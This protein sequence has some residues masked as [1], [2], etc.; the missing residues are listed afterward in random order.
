MSSAAAARTC[1]DHRPRVTYDTNSHFGVL[2]QM[3]GS[4]WPRVLPHCLLNILNVSAIIYLDRKYDIDLSYSDKGHSFMSMIVSF[5]IVTRSNIAYSRFMESRSYLSTVMRSCRELMQYAVT[6]TRY[7]TSETA[8]KYRITL[9]RKTIVLL[10]SVVSVLQFPSR[11][12]HSWKNPILRDDE[13]QA[14]IDAV[15]EEDNVRAPMILAMFLRTS[16]ASHIEYLMTPMHVNREL[17]LYSFVSDF[18]SGY[19][20]LTK[21][22]DTQFPFPLAQMTRTFVFIWVYSLPWVLYNDEIKTPSLIMIVFFITYAFVGLECVSIELD[23]PYGNDANDFDV[24]GLAYVVF[25][26]IQICI[27]DVD[28]K[29][30]AEKLDQF[31]VFGDTDDM[32]E[33]SIISE[34]SQRSIQNGSI[35]LP[36]PA[37][38]RR[39][40]SDVGDKLSSIM[41]SGKYHVDSKSRKG[42]V[43]GTDDG[44]QLSG[45]KY[46]NER[47]PLLP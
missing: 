26:D 47:H 15:G 33:H 23:D 9:A 2:T 17:R 20:G 16:I 24:L 35:S 18:V 6:F 19:H 1:A 44:N 36:G 40:S 32:T 21:L 34:K 37:H 27:Y 8:K 29:E 22:I 4:V 25:Q 3:H 39:Q 42:V 5:L 14:L 45:E 7:D 46:G 43:F 30:Q 10:R 41:Q 11:G 13:A 28:G 31:F 12:E 38:Y